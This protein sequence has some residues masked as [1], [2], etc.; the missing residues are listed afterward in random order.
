MSF[1]D[2]FSYIISKLYSTTSTSSSKRPLP[3][4][5]VIFILE[6]FDL[7]ALHPKQALLYNLFDVVQS[8][9]NAIA[10][11]A[12]T[13][14]VV[15]V[16][17]FLKY[18]PSP[19]LLS[20]FLISGYGCYHLPSA[21]QQPFRFDWA[22]LLYLVMMLELPRL[23]RRGRFKFSYHVDDLFFKHHLIGSSVFSA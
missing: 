13:C 10:V 4:P 21:T 2:C 19:S 5:V 14:R 7:F 23:L 16:F 22:D 6:E 3:R 17:F 12:S 8:S 1:A 9:P 20:A 11:V 15:S 18:C